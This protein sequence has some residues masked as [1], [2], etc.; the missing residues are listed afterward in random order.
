MT[1]GSDF[2]GKKRCHLGIHYARGKSIKKVV[3]CLN[4]NKN[5]AKEA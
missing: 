4:T 1:G 3:E 2:H 5:D